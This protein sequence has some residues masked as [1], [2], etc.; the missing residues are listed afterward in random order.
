MKWI[1]NRICSRGLRILVDLEIEFPNAESTS[2]SSKRLGFF[3]KIINMACN[4][5]YDKN[6]IYAIH[7]VI[8]MNESIRKELLGKIGINEFIS[9][10]KMLN[11]NDLSHIDTCKNLIKVMSFTNECNYK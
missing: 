5:S 10:Y 11:E 2:S 4:T 3:T 7:N 9:Q 6:I 8:N 1:L